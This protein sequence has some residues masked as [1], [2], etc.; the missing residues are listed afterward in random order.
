[1]TKHVVPH[2]WADVLAGH[3]SRGE[4]AEME[5]HAATCPRCDRDRVRVQRVSDTFPVIREQPA[6]ELGWDGVRARIHWAVSKA[7][8]Q[9]DRRDG[10]GAPGELDADARGAS[11]SRRR[12]VPIVAA[13][14]AVVVGGVGVYSVTRSAAPAP[15]VAPIAHASVAHPTPAPLTALVSRLA[16]DVMI[17]GARPADAGAAFARPLGAGTVIA[18]GDGR[19]DV[20]FGEA[21]AFALGPRSTLELRTFDADTIAL[22]VEGSVDLE[23]APRA[24]HQRFFVIA[25][26]R[27]IEVRGTRFAVKQDATGTLVS[28]Q[29]GLVAVRDATAHEVEV[30]T[31]RRAFVPAGH[32][33]AEAHA[34]P[35]TAD[36]LAGLAAATPWATPGWSAALA[37]RSAPLEIATA[38]PHQVVRVDGLELG[39][40]PFAMRVMP[41]RHTIEAADP[42][43][44]FQRAG[45]VDVNGSEVAHFEAPAVDEPALAAS[46]NAAIRARRHEFAAGIA[47][48]G[49][50]PCMRRLAKSGLTD[51]FVQIEITVDASGA[52]NVLNIIDTD[53]PAGTA[54][55]VHD[56]LSN[57]HFAAGPAA[58]WRQK[59]TL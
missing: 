35:L 56:A 49:I 45:W 5:R 59:L 15:R 23:V 55:C 26:D 3:V 9:R 33:T 27:T 51:T 2:R 53:L 16:G 52:V 11:G 17:D 44:R 14:A 54:A 12:L 34:V 43:G 47:R 48:A 21:S 4:R 32:G 41:G 7:R 40:A 25:G 28:C 39:L 20:Q 46:P 6:P 1:M 30:G 8:R 50:Q 37:A 42:A 24:K 58:S 18:T 22:V 10:H 36:E 19:L 13:V 29:H 31:A 57:I 38:V